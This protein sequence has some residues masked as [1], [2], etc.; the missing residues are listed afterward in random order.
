VLFDILG[1]T[2][3]AAALAAQLTAPAKR[4]KMLSSTSVCKAGCVCVCVAPAW[5][6]AVCLVYPTTL[7]RDQICEHTLS[8]AVCERERERARASKRERERERERERAVCDWLY[9]VWLLPRLVLA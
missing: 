4:Q 6:Y 9:P 5:L 1:V 7:T 3:Q 8:M 2:W